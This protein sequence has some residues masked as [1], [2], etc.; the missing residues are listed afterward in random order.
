MESEF[1]GHLKGSF[2]GAHRDK[3]GLFQA[4]E[5]GTLFLDE[6]ADLPAH[7]QVKLLRA[8]HERALRPVGAASEIAVHVRVISATHKHLGERVSTGAFRSEATRVGNEC[9]DKCKYRRSR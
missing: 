6:V 2:T 8:L 3:T 5:N 4:A 9:V 1:F 7:M